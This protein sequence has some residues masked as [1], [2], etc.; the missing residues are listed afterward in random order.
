MKSKLLIINLSSLAVA[1]FLVVNTSPVN[2]Q[3]T[4]KK[5][6]DSKIEI[7]NIEAQKALIIKADV[8]TSSI[9]EKM[10]EMYGKLFG[11]LGQKQKQPTGP[12][13]AAYSK[14]DPQGNTVFEAGV[15]LAEKIEGEGEIEYKEYPAMK[16]VSMLYIGP[17]ENMMPA[18]EKIQKYIEENN[19]KSNNTPWELYLTDPTSEPDPNK[20]QT[21]IYFPVE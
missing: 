9:G 2:S 16:V 3:D 5:S 6:C 4:G 20:Y 17:Y 1:L 10:S 21:L 8:P 7:K 15:P 11:Y 19:L 12:S 18:Y 13:F 14:F